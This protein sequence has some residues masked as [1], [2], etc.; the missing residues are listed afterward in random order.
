MEVAYELPALESWY[1]TTARDAQASLAKAAGE[2]LLPTLT[3]I[4]PMTLVVFVTLYI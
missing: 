1:S 4:Q 2:T 3:L